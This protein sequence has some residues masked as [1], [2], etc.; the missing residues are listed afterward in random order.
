MPA[1]NNGEMVMVRC[2]QQKWLSGVIQRRSIEGLRVW[3][4][5]AHILVNVPLALVPTH[6]VKISTSSELQTLQQPQGEHMWTMTITDNSGCRKALMQCVRPAH[7][8]HRQLLQ[9]F[10]SIE[11]ALCK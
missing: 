4:S 11:C 7:L 2:N 6:V 3:L 1:Y 9:K 5:D 8:S 10:G